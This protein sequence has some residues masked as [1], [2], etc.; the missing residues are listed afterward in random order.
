MVAKA[1]GI[2]V[3]ERIGNKLRPVQLGYGSSGGCEA[4]VHATRRFL[5]NSGPRVLITRTPS[6]VYDEIVFLRL[7]R[8]SFLSYT[9]LYGRHIVPLQLSFLGIS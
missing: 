9:P 5:S 2:L 8:V 3:G 4:A 7:S 6:T 1:A